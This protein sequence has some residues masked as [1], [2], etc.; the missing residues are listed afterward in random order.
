MNYFKILKGDGIKSLLCFLDEK[1]VLSDKILYHD[2]EFFGESIIYNIHG[3][4]RNFKLFSICLRLDELDYIGICTHNSIFS[5]SELKTTILGYL[6][7]LHRE[8]IINGL[9]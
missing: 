7:F 5:E 6:K 1:Y 8:K 2:I 9:L 3:M 4:N